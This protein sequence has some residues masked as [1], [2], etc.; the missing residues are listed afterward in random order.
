LALRPEHYTRNRV[1]GEPR[2]RAGEGETG[3]VEDPEKRS[4]EIDKH[5]VA[6]GRRF[7]VVLVHD[8][9]LADHERRRE[10]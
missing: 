1:T 3:R 9:A 7:I 2:R 4:A 5:H 6:R 10:A 8:L